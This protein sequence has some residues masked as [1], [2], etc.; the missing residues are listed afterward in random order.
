MRSSFLIMLMLM[1]LAACGKTNSY[2]KKQTFLNP[3]QMS[4]LI[5]TQ[6]IFCSEAAFCP[7][8]VARMF[9]VNFQDNAQS[10]TCSAFLIAD[11]LVLTNS[12]CIWTG[13]IGLE[14]TCEGLYFAF[15]TP[16]GQTQSAQCSKILWRDPKQNGR[17]TYR[18]GDNDFALI[19]LDHKVSIRPLKLNSKIQV[20]QIVHP[21]VMDQYDAISARVTK[22]SCEVALIN[23]HGVATLNDCPIISGNSGSAVLDEN[24]TVLG[25]VFASSNAHVRTAQDELEV[26]IQGAKTLGQVYTTA[27]IQKIL[28]DKLNSALLD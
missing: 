24:Q 20:G 13:D 22:L 21:L 2:S 3:E 23:K 15:P 6:N 5:R 28:G 19:K 10:S 16:H 11:D 12:H 18:Q 1:L 17:S 7:E 8:G 9:A 25:V 26:R 27:H 4:A 14:K